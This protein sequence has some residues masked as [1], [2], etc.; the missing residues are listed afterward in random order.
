MSTLRRDE[1]IAPR[2]GRDTKTIIDTALEDDKT[3]FI[4][5]FRD[6]RFEPPDPN[7]RSAMTRYS[8]RVPRKEVALSDKE[9]TQRPEEDLDISE[10]EAEKVRGGNIPADGGAVYRAP[11]AHKSKHVKHGKHK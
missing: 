1:Y 2:T 5:N 8:R 11:S 7:D 6:V 3:K 4:S 9:K 10:K